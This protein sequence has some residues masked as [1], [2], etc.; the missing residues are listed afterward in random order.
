MNS[1]RT[2]S[3]IYLLALILVATALPATAQSLVEQNIKAV[4]AQMDQ[5]KVDIEKQ[6]L[7]SLQ[8]KAKKDLR[9]AAGYDATLKQKQNLLAV[10]QAQLT[11]YQQQ[12]TLS[13]QKLSENS[14]IAG[15]QMQ[16]QQL[17]IDKSKLAIS[18]LQATQAGNT[19]Q[20]TALQ[21]QAQAKQ[22]LIQAKQQEIKLIELQAKTGKR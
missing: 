2:L 13:N 21:Q 7:L 12:L 17:T 16:I 3:R 1:V 11:M 22:A 6:R 18:Q 10:K 5:L 19:P 14:V 9:S 8:A 15:I 20:A 4:T